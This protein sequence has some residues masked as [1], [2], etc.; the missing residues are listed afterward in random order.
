MKKTLAIRVRLNKRE[1]LIRLISDTKK[2]IDE[3]TRLL[4]IYEQ[5][6]RKVNFELA[7]YDK[8]II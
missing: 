6:L 1:S 4:T 7:D 3:A 2:D 8:S 5:S